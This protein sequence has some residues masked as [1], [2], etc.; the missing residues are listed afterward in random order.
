M[1][2]RNLHIQFEHIVR[3]V[4]WDCPNG[5][6]YFLVGDGEQ[7]YLDRLQAALD[8]HF[9]SDT[10]WASPSRHEAIMLERASA[11]AIVAQHVTRAG[12]FTV[13][14]SDLRRFMQFTKT[15]VARQGVLQANNSCMDSLCKQR[16][17]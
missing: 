15:G 3:A 8:Q 16:M 17:D 14:D 7:F 11:A 12:S 10:L 2:P 4:H 1:D 6:E 13:F 9:S 5:N